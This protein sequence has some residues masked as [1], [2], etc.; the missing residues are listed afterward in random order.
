MTDTNPELQHYLKTWNVSN[1][2]LL[3]QTPTSH[4]YMVTYEQT[5]VVLKILTD[6]GVEERIGALALRHFQGNGAVRLLHSDD[7]AQLLEYAEGEDV[8]ELVRKGQDEA[9]TGVI[10]EVVNA[11]HANDAAP[12]V[13]I[14]LLRT[15]F[16]SLFAQ[17]EQD[18]NGDLN[19]I[20]RH[21][22]ARADKVFAEPHEPRV[23][24]GDIHHANIRH[25]AR[26]WLAFDPKGLYGERTYDLANTLCNPVPLYGA[27][28]VV[29]EGRILHNA[30]ILAQRCSID[31]ARVL[32]FLYLYACLTASWTLEGAETGWA[33]DTILKIAVI[34]KRYMGLYGG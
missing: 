4:I 29:D 14:T 22:A 26:G 34:A 33:L 8:T 16:R 28:M 20:L 25:S 18:H 31:R 9:A 24:H 30:G 15:W 1:P 27:A 2:Q 5:L 32:L 17:A 23:L 21:A 12:P 6:Y 7:G 11:L 3:A 10:A 19:A 13:G